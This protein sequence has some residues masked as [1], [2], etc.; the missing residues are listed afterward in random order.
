MLQVKSFKIGDDKGINELL[1]KYRL[2]EG[3]H[4]LVSNGEVCIPYEDGQALSV[5]QKVASI[6]EQQNKFDQERDIIV[7]SNKVLE[8]LL[9]NANERVKEAEANLADADKNYT[10]KEK[11]AAKKELQKKVDEAKNA[12]TQLENQAL[13]NDQEITRLSL[14]IEIYDKQIAELQHA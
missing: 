7:H 11:Y 1:S 2:A 14:S 4:I 3:A 9:N 8:F 5:E 6:R 12:V 13:Q 10:G